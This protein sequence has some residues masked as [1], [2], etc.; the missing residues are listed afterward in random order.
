M[1][2]Y[3]RII[4]LFAVA[5]LLM[6]SHGCIVRESIH[7]AA[8]RGDVA[9]VKR[10]VSRSPE[11][12]YAKDSAGN[13]PLHTAAAYDQPVVAEYLLAIGATVSTRN[14]HGETPLQVAERTGHL[15]TAAILRCQFLCE[16]A[17]RGDETAILRW[18]RRGVSVNC[19]AASGERPIH[20]AVRSRSPSVIALL[21]RHGADVNA[22]SNSPCGYD[23]NAGGAW[24]G[25]TPLILAA[26]TDDASIVLELLQRGAKVDKSDRAGVT[27]LD[28][29]AMTADRKDMV[30]LLLA[31]TANAM[32]RDNRGLVPLHYAAS[33]KTASV[34]V[35]GY[36]VKLLLADGAVPGAV[37]HKGNTA[38]HQA[39]YSNNASVVAILADIGVPVNVRNKDGDTALSL[40]ARLGDKSIARVLMAH[41][42]RKDP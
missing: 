42:A 38:L 7:S 30:A 10:M 21:A 12:A 8:R 31:H 26:R 39:V 32:A 40:A 6:L 14:K 11:L 18:L 19:R 4:A 41:G 16:A 35:I 9:A 34:S 28:Y 17:T 23:P 5:L 3:N 33:N 15:S 13:T 25:V 2:A 29:A 37:D 20:Y 24:C 1:K 22:V 36:I 27:P